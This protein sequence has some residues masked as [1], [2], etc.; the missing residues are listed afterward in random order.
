[1]SKHNNLVLKMVVTV[2][3]LLFVFSNT[4]VDAVFVFFQKYT[5]PLLVTVVALQLFASV[6]GSIRWRLLL[7]EIPFF[8]ILRFT[9]VGQFYS[10]V[11]PGQISGDVVKGY[12]M[13]VGKLYDGNKIAASILAD[14]LLG[15]L[16]LIIVTIF[17]LI[18]TTSEDVGLIVVST[19]FALFL[20]VLILLIKKFDK[21]PT[22]RLLERYSP[23]R[24]VVHTL[25]NVYVQ[26]RQ[27]TID[28]RIL[29]LSFFLAV[30]FQLVAIIITY[31][32][33]QELGMETIFFDWFWIFGAVSLAVA[34]PTTI[35]GLG[36]REGVFVFFLVRLGE[37]QEAALALSLSIFG[38]QFIIAL[39][40]AVLELINWSKSDTPV[41]I[42]TNTV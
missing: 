14:K 18:I 26:L 7:P 5:G 15:F 13:S 31:L 20:I 36:I 42:S 40:G 41:Q 27:Y 9:F 10:F 39:I 33:A 6:I 12:R 19:L 32:L 3:L 2:L 25:S 16:G 1:M 29:F 30:I 28:I 22:L 34:F 37:S 35:A 38:L 23:L 4:S 17:G 8:K 11:L 21:F 24:K